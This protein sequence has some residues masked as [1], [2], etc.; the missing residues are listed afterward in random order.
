[1]TSLVRSM[2]IAAGI[3][4]LAGIHDASAQITDPVEFTAAFPFIVGNASVPAGTYTI[5]P[6]ED[7]LEILHLAGPHTSVFFQT[8]G[9]QGAQTP[10]KTEVV[11]TRYGDQYVLKSVWIDGIRTGA[12]TRP[13]EAERHAAKNNAAGAE[14]RL[15]GRKK[16]R[17]NQQ[18]AG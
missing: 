13:A 14:Q 15:E 5:T 9:A 2:T 8:Q 4:V 17:R 12:E 7:N 10:S 6:D 18:P 1:M 11:F 3:M 16:A